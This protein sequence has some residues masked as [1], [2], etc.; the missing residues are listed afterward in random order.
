MSLTDNIL[1]SWSFEGNSIDASGNGNNGTDTAITYASGNGAVGQYASFNGSTS[2]I[3]LGSTSRLNPTS[4]RISIAARVYPGTMTNGT[5]YTVIAKTNGSTPAGTV[6]TFSLVATGANTAQLHLDTSDHTNIYSYTTTAVVTFTG[7][8]DVGVV[9][10]GS[11]YTFYVNGTVL[12][13]SAAGSYTHPLN[14]S[15]TEADIGVLS[16]GVH[17]YVGYINYASV[18]NRVLISSEWKQLI[19]LKYP[20][21]V[22]QNQYQRKHVYAKVSSSKGVFIKTWSSFELQSFTKTLNGGCGE[23]VLT[24]NVPFDYAG[25]DLTEGNDVE[26]HISD[27]DTLSG[28][29]VFGAKMVYK[30]YISLVEREVDE[31]VERVTV[32]LLGYYTLLDLDV[33]KNGT[34]TTLYSN[35]STGL[36]T[37]SG[38]NNDADVGLMVRA[39]VD[40]FNAENTSGRIFYNATDIP[41]ASVTAKYVFQQKTYFEALTL[42]KSLAPANTYW[43]VDET[44]RLQFKPV[45]TTPTYTFI[46]GR[47]FSKAHIE[48]SL[49]KVRNVLL[50]YDGAGSI[51]KH[52]E[53]AASIAKYGRRAQRQTLYGVGNT[54]TTDALASKFFS[55][56]KNPSLKLNATIFDDNNARGLGMDIESIQPGQT[57]NIVGYSSQLSNIFQENMIITSVTYRL[58]SVDIQVE[59]ISGNVFDRLSQTASDVSS[60]NSGKAG[61]T[62]PVTYT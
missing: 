27:K 30:G 44:G 41:N 42:L 56:W 38:S 24:Y 54:A 11:S 36:T 58:D 31:T 28:T 45:P 57:C 14:T 23:C 22:T 46:F 6:F 34:Q 17:P 37:S 1:G 60:I 4:S 48:R 3:G 33:L 2:K 40:R 62:I 53:D 39:L 7:F 51:Y 61:G 13:T 10:D 35:S 49:E 19:A 8:V 5:Y 25:D 15:N 47:H 55:E 59:I 16:T 50:V 12:E 32:H 52:Y 43:Y 20:F 29:N 9:Y 21:W 18:W 26:I